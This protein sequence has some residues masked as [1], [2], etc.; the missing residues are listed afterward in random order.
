MA[1]RIQPLGAAVW[2]GALS[3]GLVLALVLGSGAAVALRAELGAQLGPADWAA[4][5]FTLLQATL[6][7]GL[8]TILAIPVARALARRA[9][10]GR[11]VLVTL[12]GAPF[13][14]PVIVAILG[15]LAVFGRNGLVSHLFGLI[16][17]APLD[18]YGLHGV[19]LAHVF[20]NLPLTTRLV[21]H[22][23]QSIPS[24]QFRLASALGFSSGDIARHLERP[25]LARVL[26]GAFLVVFLI[27]VTSF[28]VVLALGGGPR[29]TTIELAIYQAFRF[30]FD[31]G[32]AA[33]LAA[34]QFAICAAIAG[35]MLVVRVPQPGRTG[36]DRVVQR[37]DRQGVLPRLVD[38]SWIILVCLFLLVPLGMVVAR[39]VAGMQQLPWSVFEAAARSIMVAA[40]SVMLAGIMALSIAFS[41]CAWGPKKV[42]AGLVEGAGY[43][44]I[45]ASPLV[46]GLG[47]YILLNPIA[48]PLAL[49]LPLTATVNAAMSL[50]FML[51][52]LVPAVAGIEAQYGRLAD[53]LGLRGVARIRYLHFPRL[54]PSLGFASGLAAALSLGD[55]GVIAL[56]SSGERATL[57]LQIYRL[58]G[59]YRMEQ[60]AGAALLLLIMALCAF[61]LFDRG[62]RLDVDA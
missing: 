58:M 51:R 60:A 50:P 38:A 32:R 19:V 31:L 48:D 54:R 17:L 25:M 45:S 56:F 53:S 22:G 23:W 34:I 52:V 4:I 21:L 59:S 12:L 9:F 46:M 55:L 42:R 28:A 15:L 49:A 16:G 33:L 5:R 44:A 18:I 36:L 20:F 14:L 39:G 3:A 57:P 35:A 8:S 61:W 40:M 62:G 10:I 47:L 11:R 6:S 27:C 43:L 7:A 13:I 24:E 29:A 2:A 41:A 37:F 30:D 26:P 1:K